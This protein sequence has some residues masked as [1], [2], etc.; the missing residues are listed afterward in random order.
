MGRKIT[1]NPISYFT[2][3]LIITIKQ[4]SKDQI[5]LFKY[6]KTRIV[7]MALSLGIRLVILLPSLL[8]IVGFIFKSV[9]ERNKIKQIKKIDVEIPK[10]IWL[11][12][13]F[14]FALD[15]IFLVIANGLI[16]MF[17][18]QIVEVGI[19]TIIVGVII[20]MFLLIGAYIDL[21]SYSGFG[22]GGIFA[23]IGG[24][25]TFFSFYGWELIIWNIP[26]HYISPI[27]GASV[28]GLI[29]LLVSSPLVNEVYSYNMEC[30][31]N[32]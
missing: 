9:V 5:V 14:L 31:L 13:I 30:H 11:D 21:P 7:I 18:L 15:S 3:S 12:F 28:V 10:K 26:L 24:E 29:G 2:S 27:I 23:L 25:L 16:I 20:S 1:E 17:E 22:M 8:F 6:G 19:V 32:N 4:D